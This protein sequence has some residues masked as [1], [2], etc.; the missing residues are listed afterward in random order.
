MERAAEGKRIAHS[1]T[2]GG[3]ELKKKII[4]H[5]KFADIELYNNETRSGRTGYLLTR[6]SYSIY[7]IL[8]QWLVQLLF[9]LSLYY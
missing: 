5:M 9:N 2:M 3:G 7:F 6:T 1:A 8:N 4:A